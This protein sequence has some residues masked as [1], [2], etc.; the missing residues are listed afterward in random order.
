MI[1][2]LTKE[3]VMHALIFGE[4]RNH[5][6][7]MLF[8]QWLYV[9][10]KLASYYATDGFTKFFFFFFLIVISLSLSLHFHCLCQMKILNY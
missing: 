4:E 5:N 10:S 3:R 7:T 8:D 9:G 2:L 1:E 6:A